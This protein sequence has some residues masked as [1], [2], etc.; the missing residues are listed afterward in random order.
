MLPNGLWICFN[1]NVHGVPILDPPV[2]DV[3]NQ[4]SDSTLD[5]P[6]KGWPT[7][8]AAYIHIPFCRH[9]CGYC[10][11]SVITQRDDLI[12]DVLH[13][14][15]VELAVLDRPLLNTL[16]VGGGTPTHLDC[17]QLERLLKNLTVRFH[18]PADRRDFEWTMEANPEDITENKLELLAEY[19]VNRLS[20]GVQSFHPKKLSILE[21]SH[22][23]EQAADVIHKT[24][25]YIP[26]ISLDLIF[27][28]PGEL[29][30]WFQE[31][32][33]TA[34]SLPIKHLS[35]YALTYEKGTSFWSRRLH[36]RLQS[37]DE[38]LEV[39]LYHAA[40]D[41]TA[42]AGMT[43]YEISSF[44]HPESMCRH[45][46]Q[47]WQGQGW[48]AAGPGATRFVNGSRTTNHR[49]TTTY[50]KKIR[51]Q[52][53]PIAERE[54]LSPREYA[55]ELMAFGVRML[56]GVDLEQINNR[57]GLDM[58]HLFRDQIQKLLHS[59]MIVKTLGGYRLS[60]HGLLYADSVAAKF[61][62]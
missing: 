49:S 50:L 5:A 43:H 40:R 4:A 37:M 46:L 11:F 1:H 28:A 2:A 38:E 53:G 23:A 20:L 15:D 25:K 14:I 35:T 36:G 17:H 48:Y 58:D 59:G 12:D 18:F 8:S 24:S 32:L 33:T 60:E 10:N 7:T 54:D 27:G 31:D 55:K 51:H 13:A 9:R 30:D 29:L 61:L 34:L 57:T 56:A 19:G 52:D 44:A 16:F 6:P 21:R 47:Y 41:L 39:D 42:K 26:N 3:K 22:T 62:D 45:N